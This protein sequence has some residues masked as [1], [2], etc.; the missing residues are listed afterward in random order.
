MISAVTPEPRTDA[1]LAVVRLPAG[2]PVV[3]MGIGI[4]GAQNAALTA[5]GILA[6]RA[7]DV[8]EQLDR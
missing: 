3:T 1:L 7:S 8:A 4:A 6:V 2:I 5:A